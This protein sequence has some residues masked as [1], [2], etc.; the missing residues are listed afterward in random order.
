MDPT[1]RALVGEA[2]DKDRTYTADE[3]RK[4][5]DNLVRLT[6]DVHGGSKR[7]RQPTE[8]L[9]CDFHRQ[10][11]DSVRGHAGTIRKRGVGSETL[12][13][14]PNRSPRREEVPDQLY[15]IFSELQKG[16]RSFDENPDAPHYDRSALHL[17]AWSHAE[18]IRVHPFEDGNGRC[19]RLTLNW[20][21]VRLGLRPIAFEVTKQ[22]YYDT[23][24]HYFRT[25]DLD[26]FLDLVLRLYILSLDADA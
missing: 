5:T 26:P 9:L 25:R 2:P 10:L 13:F 19:S 16:L 8:A 14:G 4:L 20:I 22:E 1:T 11:F 18:I 23:L 6:S 15:V 21:L 3:E 17:A 12:I 7:D 24:N